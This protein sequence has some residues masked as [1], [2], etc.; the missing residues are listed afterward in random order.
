MTGLTSIQ[1][2]GKAVGL[3]FGM[4]AARIIVGHLV[5]DFER[6]EKKYYNERDI[7]NLLYAGYLNHCT[8]SDVEPTMT[9]GKWIDF[10]EDN[11]D[12]MKPEF[13][14]IA[15]V[16]EESK[17]SRRTLD[18]LKVEE[19]VKKKKLPTGKKSK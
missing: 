8:I 15:R 16:F 17:S 2:N 10:V 1:V 19:E 12:E 13:E 4:Q 11:L 14:R 3:K 18:A 7:A 9:L 5:L 6:L